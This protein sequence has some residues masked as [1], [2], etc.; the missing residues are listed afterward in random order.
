MSKIMTK[1]PKARLVLLNSINSKWQRCVYIQIPFS[2]NVLRKST[3]IWVSPKEWDDKTES[4]TSSTKEAS[5]ITTKLSLQ[6]EKIR[7]QLLKLDLPIRIETV[8]EILGNRPKNKNCLSA[9]QTLLNTLI[10]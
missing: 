10:R 1:T 2:G 5:L 4:I 8:Q 3:D 9:I 6:I 7:S